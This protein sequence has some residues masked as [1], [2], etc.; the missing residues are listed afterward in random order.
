MKHC[1]LHNIEYRQIVL[2]FNFRFYLNLSNLEI[3][4]VFHINFAVSVSYRSSKSIFNEN[5]DICN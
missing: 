3:R 2:N 4:L 5:I 1:Y